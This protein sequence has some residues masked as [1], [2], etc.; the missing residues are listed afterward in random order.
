M[1][2]QRS[3]GALRL[4]SAL[5]LAR[6][7]PGQVPGARSLHEGAAVHLVG[8]VLVVGPAAKT[9]LGGVVG[10]Y[11]G[12]AVCVIELEASGLFA[13][14]AAVVHEGAA[15]AIALVDGAADRG[16]DV[17]GCGLAW[18]CRRGGGAG[19]GADSEALLLGRREELIEG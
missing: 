3:S 18:N 19:L 8:A 7:A 16:G 13:A 17:A 2:A 5:S 12:E 14:V 11:A 1:Q 15:A 4:L 9:N 6:L 10:S